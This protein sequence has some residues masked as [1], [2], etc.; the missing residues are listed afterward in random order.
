MKKVLRIITILVVILGL[1][2]CSDLA[3]SSNST[4]AS[5]SV[6][7]TTTTFISR[8]DQVANAIYNDVHYKHWLTECCSKV[9]AELGTG[10]MEINVTV[11]YLESYQFMAVVTETVRCIN[12][13]WEEYWLDSV[14]LTVHTPLDLNNYIMWKSTDL[15]KGMLIDTKK[16]ITKNITIDDMI[17]LYGYEGLISMTQ[18]SSVESSDSSSQSN[19][20]VETEEG[21]SGVP[22][23]GRPGTEYYVYGTLE[24]GTEIDIIGYENDDW[25]NL[26]FERKNAY[27]ESKFFK[28]TA[29]NHG[30]IINPEAE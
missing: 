5:P 11:D 22:A 20:T 12:D 9:T 25:I 24:Y 1:C 28:P 27:I 29:G 13:I 6:P 26:T 21:V 3:T 4:T 8:Y 19:V 16:G 2:G 7:S 18:E 23:Y 14:E 30:I 10:C 15:Y 17:Q